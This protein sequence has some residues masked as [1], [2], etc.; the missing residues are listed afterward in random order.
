[1]ENLTLEVKSKIINALKEERKL[2]VGSDEK[3]ARKL[4]INAAQWSRLNMGN[5]FQ[6][7]SDSVW[8]TL[9][10]GAD[11][12]MKGEPMWIAA[13]TYTFNFIHSALKKC[14]EKSLSAIFCDEAGVG[15][16][17][18]AKQYAKANRMVAYIDCSQVKSRP[19]LVRQIAREFGVEHTGTYKNVYADL[20]YYLRSAAIK[21]LVILDEAGDLDYP[22]FLEL[23]AL[24]NA[25]EKYCAWYMM[26]ADGLE[27]KINRC[28]EYKKVGYTELFSRFG[29]K[30]QRCTPLGAEDREA[31]GLKE[32]TMIIKANAP[33]GADI[34][35]I[36]ID[37]GFVKGKDKN[38]KAEVSLR[39]IN[40]AISKL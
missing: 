35:K 14:Q 39:R 16:T 33:E 23:K 28:I 40:T 3:F 4:G 1:M 7:I 18:A 17:F 31:H 38:K 37:A 9:A 13:R 2:F 34:Q 24:W 30:F 20:T 5:F 22:A 8:I 11:V 26:G 29:K 15:K 21:P 25:T 6:V 36:L 12:N 10:R 32:A 27:T 19:L